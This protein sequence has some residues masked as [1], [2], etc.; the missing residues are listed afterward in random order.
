MTT[1]QQAHPL[2]FAPVDGEGVDLNTPE[3][4]E[5]QKNGDLIDDAQEWLNVYLLTLP[6]NLTTLLPLRLVR[7]VLCYAKP[8]SMILQTDFSIADPASCFCL[9]P[10]PWKA[11]M[12]ESLLFGFF[13]LFFDKRDSYLCKKRISSFISREIIQDKSRFSFGESACLQ[14]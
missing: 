8:S 14:I 11:S 13:F 3:S 4:Q 9:Q 7:L 10:L 1:S 5:I 2:L 12:N 6:G